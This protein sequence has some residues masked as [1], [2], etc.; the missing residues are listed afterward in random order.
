MTLFSAV[1][2]KKSSCFCLQVNKEL[3]VVNNPSFEMLRNCVLD[4]KEMGFGSI[5]SHEIWLRNLVSTLLTCA[6]V[7]NKIFLIL[8]PLCQLH[9]SFNSNK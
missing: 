2:N 5:S 9:V 6:V 8:E 7:E 3:E 4:D 1:L